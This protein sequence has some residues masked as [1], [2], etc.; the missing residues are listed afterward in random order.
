M[1]PLG[2][3][4]ADDNMTAWPL[5]GT[6]SWRGPARWT[7]LWSTAPSAQWPAAASGP[8]TRSWHMI[9]AKLV[10]SPIDEAS[11]YVKLSTQRCKVDH[12][13]EEVHW[14]KIELYKFDF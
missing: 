13:V 10:L 11:R 8:R 12:R 7:P 4:V 2:W 14:E 6:P 9:A 3:I 1:R 5:L